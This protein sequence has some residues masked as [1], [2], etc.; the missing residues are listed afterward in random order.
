[1]AAQGGSLLDY[2]FKRIVINGSQLT[3]FALRN[4]TR[5]NNIATLDYTFSNSAILG[6]IPVTAYI[7]YRK[8]DNT[9]S[10]EAFC[11]G[12]V[13]VQPIVISLSGSPST[14]PAG[15][16]EL[17]VI[18]SGGT[19]AAVS[20]QY[21]LENRPDGI[22]TYL[23]GTTFT[24]EQDFEFQQQR[25]RVT[26]LRLVVRALNAQGQQVASISRNLSFLPPL[27]C[28]LNN[29]PT[30][31]VKNTLATFQPLAVDELG[32]ATGE[33]L[34]VSDVRLNFGY[35]QYL[36]EVQ[37]LGGAGQVSM[38]F[39]HPLDL[40]FIPFQIILSSA[41]G[42]VNGR[43]CMITTGINVVKP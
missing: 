27:L 10:D 24:V 15:R 41:D 18:V 5:A 28:R 17:G 9:E 40:L 20:I 37:G 30:T 23:N 29:P 43:T 36:T 6:D 7:T 34:I 22:V 8:A 13:R 38:K 2:N 19:N 39:T 42:T 33:P 32:R 4:T 21:S 12:T 1:V 14:T 16:I 3:N 25:R 26:G 11:S 31:V 35:E